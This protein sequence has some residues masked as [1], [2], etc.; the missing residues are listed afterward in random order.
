M[1]IFFRIEIEPI[2]RGRMVIDFDQVPRMRWVTL[3]RTVVQRFI[4]SVSLYCISPSKE[5]ILGHPTK[6][7]KLHISR[8]L[9]A[10]S[11][12]NLGRSWWLIRLLL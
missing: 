10:P 5:V 1:R 12:D 3:T 11:E 2:R 4:L 6:L 9:V 7:I 8:E